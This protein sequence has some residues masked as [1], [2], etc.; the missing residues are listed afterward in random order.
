MNNLFSI[1]NHKN[2]RQ[3]GDFFQIATPLLALCL[4]PSYGNATLLALEYIETQCLVG[5]GK[6][7]GK[8]FHFPGSARPNGSRK[9]M[10]SGH[11]AVAWIGAAHSRQ[12]LLYAMAAFTGASRVIANKH[13]IPQVMASALLSEGVALMNRKYIAPRLGA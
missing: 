6:W 3:T 7:L 13:T 2:I 5:L 10:P 11:T 12:P 9:G 4:A 1:I 8:R